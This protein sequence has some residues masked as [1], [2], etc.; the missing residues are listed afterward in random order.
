M[1]EIDIF[2]KKIL[3]ILENNKIKKVFRQRNQLKIVFLSF[4][5]FSTFKKIERFYCKEISQDYYSSNFKFWHDVLIET[6]DQRKAFFLI[7]KIADEIFDSNT[8]NNI[9]HIQEIF[10]ILNLLKLMVK[11]GGE[12]DLTKIFDRIKQPLNKEL[13]NYVSCIQSGYVDKKIILFTNKIRIEGGNKLSKAYKNLLKCIIKNY[14]N[15]KLT[16]E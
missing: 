12:L 2:L 13:K 1:N 11:K 16:I 7:N 14:L 10:K 15:K 9:K 6:K 3:K 4:L 8:E 5:S